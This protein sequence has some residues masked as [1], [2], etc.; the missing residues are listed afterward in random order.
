MAKLLVKGLNFKS[1]R[2]FFAKL[3]HFELFQNKP[4]L[5]KFQ[6]ISLGIFLEQ[7]EI[8]LY[9]ANQYKIR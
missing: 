9:Y 3:S 4:H 5:L 6:G 1:L 2:I 7:P 8:F